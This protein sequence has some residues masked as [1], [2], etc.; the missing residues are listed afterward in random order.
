MFEEMKEKIEG[1]LKDNQEH[2]NEKEHI[3]RRANDAEEKVLKVSLL[4][5][6]SPCLTSLPTVIRGEGA[7]PSSMFKPSRYGLQHSTGMSEPGN[8]LAY[9]DIMQKDVESVSK[10]NEKLRKDL[11]ATTNQVIFPP[12]FLYNQF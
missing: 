1:T 7:A 3:L 4:R 2:L 5:P 8:M 10:E 11:D 12:L 6:P 9:V